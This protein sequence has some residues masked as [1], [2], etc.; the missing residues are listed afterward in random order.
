MWL[1]SEKQ[2]KAINFQAPQHAMC[3]VWGPVREW[4]VCFE[5]AGAGPQLIQTMSSAI[6]KLEDIAGG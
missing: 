3:R 1:L 4:Q 5:E 6:R 2:L